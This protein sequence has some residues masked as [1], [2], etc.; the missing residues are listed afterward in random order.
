[1]LKI[2]L[3]V[4]ERYILSPSGAKFTFVNWL[5]YNFN[6]LPL[7]LFILLPSLIEND[8]YAFSILKWYL[9]FIILFYDVMRIML[10]LLLFQ[11]LHE[12][13]VQGYHRRLDM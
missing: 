12:G 5:G 7:H 4:V 2:H 10:T 1:M 11:L 3:V 6:C 13:F 9:K 8:P